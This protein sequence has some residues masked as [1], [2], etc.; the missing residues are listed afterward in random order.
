M[1][2][3]GLLVLAGLLLIT[4]AAHADCKADASE[5]GIRDCLAQELRD[6]DKQIN[7]VY[8]ELMQNRDTEGKTALKL[9]QRAW[10]KQRDMDCALDEKESDR[11]K[12]LTSVLADPVKTVCTV[13]HTFLRATTLNAMLPKMKEEAAG[14][15][16]T[17]QAPAFRATTPSGPDAPTPGAVFVDDGYQLLSTT[18]RQKGK[19]YFEV[20]MDHGG[21]AELG[22]VLLIVGVRNLEDKAGVAR[23][24]NIRRTQAGA[25]PVL[26]GVAVDL[27][28]GTA[29]FR[30]NGAWYVAPGSS[31]AAEIKLNREYKVSVEGSS[32]VRELFR[33]G[34]LKVNVG[35]RPFEYA[36]PDGYRPFGEQ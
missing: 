3:S 33:H 23:E 11:E 35:D 26:L 15:P 6:S 18:S 14:T 16:D 22:D 20:W 17:P 2:Y 12:W 29:Y 34:L 30:R 31:G 8:E 19:W 5:A 28:D 9:E 13:R 36:L 10:L 1:K 7:A 25:L 27:D 21:I 24:L 32:P 4:H